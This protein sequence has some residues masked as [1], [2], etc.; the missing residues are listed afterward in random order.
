[1]ILNQ[2][3]RAIANIYQKENALSR[4]LETTLDS[5]RVGLTDAI[6][7]LLFCLGLYDLI[8]KTKIDGAVNLPHQSSKIRNGTIFIRLSL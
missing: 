2:W 7:N 3:D 8:C 6:I 4:W 1:M 5:M